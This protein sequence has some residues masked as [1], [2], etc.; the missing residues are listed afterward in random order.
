MTDRVPS[1]PKRPQEITNHGD[2]RN[3]PWFWLRD[4]DDPETMEY[5]NAENAYTEAILGPESALREPYSM[6]CEPG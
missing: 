5:L 4:I 2:V 6:R 1:A 3:D